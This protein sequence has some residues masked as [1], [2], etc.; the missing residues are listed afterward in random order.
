MFK[1]F[2][3]FFFSLGL[4]NVNN[5]KLYKLIICVNTFSFI[6]DFRLILNLS[7]CHVDNQTLCTKHADKQS[8]EIF[9][10]MT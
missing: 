5:F 1:L 9:K 3:S 8:L 10:N 6:V 4:M 7:F 2:K